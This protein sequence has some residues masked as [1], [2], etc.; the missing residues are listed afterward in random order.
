MKTCTATIVLAIAA[1]ALMASIFFHLIPDGVLSDDIRW[2][3]F[4]VM[5]VIIGIFTGNVLY[6]FVN[7]FD[8]SHKEVA[9]LG[10]RW[11]ATGWYSSLSF[12]FMLC[13]II[14]A[15][16][17]QG[18]ACSFSLQIIVQAALLL[19][20]FSGIVASQ[21]SMRKATAVFNEEN[22]LISRKKD[23]RASLAELLV[24]AEN[25]QG[26]GSDCLDRIRRI[27][28]EGRYITPSSAKDAIEA[29]RAIINGCISLESAISDFSTDQPIIEERLQ[30]LERN[31]HRRKH[32]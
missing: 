1:V 21:S 31:V 23:V 25:K 26:I 27:V 4:A 14:Y 12:L 2:L 22:S 17:N 13:N 10:L 15:W 5:T 30:R 11:S 8:K 18:I 20:F 19:F 3:D 24:S 29:D 6:P 28:S 16:Q 9:A 32:L 7:M